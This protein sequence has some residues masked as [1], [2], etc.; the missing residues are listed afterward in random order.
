MIKSF[1]KS[2]ID[3]NLLIFLT[4][5]PVSFFSET[6]GEDFFPITT[7]LPINELKFHPIERNWLLFTLETPCN[8]D[9]DPSFL[10][11]TLFFSKKLGLFPR[12]LRDFVVD[13]SWGLEDPS[14]LVHMPIF[15]IYVCLY[16]EIAIIKGDQWSSYIDFYYS[17]D[18]LQNLLLIMVSGYRFLLKDKLLFVLQVLDDITQEVR[19]FVTNADGKSLEL[20]PLELPIQKRT[21]SLLETSKNTI[22]L[23]ISH[24]DQRNPIGHIGT[25]SK[26]TQKT[27]ISLRNTLRNSEG[28][29][30]FQGISGFS[31]VFLANAI[32][33]E[34]ALMLEQEFSSFFKGSEPIKPLKNLLSEAEKHLKSYITYDNGENWHHLSIDSNGKN[35]L[36][37]EECALNL[38]IGAYK[39][40]GR[41]FSKENCIGLVMGTGN[42]GRNLARRTD[43]IN[44]YLSENGGFLW[45]EVAKGSNIYEF[46]DHGGLIVMADNVRETKVIR[47]SWDYGRNWEEIGLKETVKISNIVTENDNIGLNFMI[48]AK[49]NKGK[50]V[51]SIE[52]SSVNSSV[53]S[54][55]NSSV[56]SIENSSVNSIENSSVNSIENSWENVVLTIDFEVL[57]KRICRKESDYEEWSP[58]EREK[59]ELGERRVFLK[60]K[61]KSDCFNGVQFE[62]MIRKEICECE[63]EDWK[64]DEGFYRENGDICK[65]IEE[66]EEN[67]EDCIDFYEVSSGYR[68]ISGNKCE[69]GVQYS[70]EK[71]KCPLKTKENP[72]FL[73]FLAIIVMILAV[74]KGKFIVKSVENVIKNVKFVDKIGISGDYD[75]IE[76]E[77]SAW[78]E[79]M[80]E[81]DEE[82]DEY[83]QNI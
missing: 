43:E 54:I 21:Y 23:Q 55:E 15:R 36:F 75:L 41:V 13:F 40:F 52:N 82:N 77:G 30:D 29:A 45:R 72:Y 16:R 27:A 37:N 83:N 22:F 38:N 6:C 3:E 46:G 53:N 1:E 32:D 35:P 25:F 81:I 39:G 4:N 59:C 66:N 60:R 79:N 49:K 2:P 64:C 9:S 57:H 11:K 26:K 48:I 67:F 14:Y 65:R 69:K 28:K 80:M 68:L 7:K 31:G 76:E 33:Q 73:V 61:E 47:Y 56:I 50:S 20:S 10:C 78:N 58:F 63:K 8:R 34:K 44:T 51:N 17:D 12:E 71:M 5:L 62:K 19:L 18:F 70:S 24:L 74:F 42:I